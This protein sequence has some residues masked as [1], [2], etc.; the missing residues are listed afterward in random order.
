M[1]NFNENNACDAYDGCDAFFKGVTGLTAS[2]LLLELGRYKSQADWR[3]GLT[4]S[5]LLLEQLWHNDQAQFRPGLTA[6]RLLLEPTFHNCLLWKE[7]SFFQ[8]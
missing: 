8:H 6:S 1:E 5:R 4:A 2:R 7:V 3:P